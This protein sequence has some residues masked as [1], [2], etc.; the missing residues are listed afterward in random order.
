MR[1]PLDGKT[2]DEEFMAVAIEQAKLARDLNEVPVGAVVV[3]GGKVIAKGYNSPISS[4]DP[5]AH[6][7]IHALRDA[8]RILANYRLNEC[9]LY[10]TL[11]PC[12][13][14]AG[15]IMHS[16]ISRLVFGAFDPKTGACGSIMNI[17]DEHRINHHTN[18]VSEV[19]AQQCGAI[20][21][22]FFQ[23]RRATIRTA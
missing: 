6:A 2:L 10:C 5:T 15:A 14:C 19:L 9:T 21:S 17:F 13:M 23:Q 8:S 11:E 16:R 4:R 20:L 3:F 18:V 1:T 12:I 7:E 22:E